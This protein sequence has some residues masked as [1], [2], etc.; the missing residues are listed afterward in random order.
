MAGSSAVG[1]LLIEG[2]L[3]FVMSDPSQLR[4]GG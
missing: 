1:I 4:Q 3:S 2:H